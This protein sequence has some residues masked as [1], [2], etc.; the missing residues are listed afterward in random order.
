MQDTPDAKNPSYVAMEVSDQ[1][2]AADKQVSAAGRRRTRLSGW[3]LSQFQVTLAI[4][5]IVIG[6]LVC[7]G[8]GFLSGVWFQT[9]GQIMPQDD[10]ITLADNQL[11]R[12]QK[13]SPGDREMTFYSALPSRDGTPEP[14]LPPRTATA[15]GPQ[16]ERQPPPT[17]APDASS[18]SASQSPPPRVPEAVQPEVAELDQAEKMGSTPLP[19]S[20]S[21]GRVPS[22][23]QVAAPAPPKATGEALA[24]VVPGEQFYIVQVGS[25]RKVDQ[26]YHLQD[27]LVKKGYEARIGLSMVEGKG[28]WYRVRVGRYADRGSADETAQRLQ[29]RENIDSLVMRVSP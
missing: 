5:G 16:P 28:A 18:A 15:P 1:A 2:M 10:A 23:P 27:Q 22:E 11:D 26:A 25:F 6:F 9:P 19:A 7:F 4:C 13:T 29:K 14:E 17:V 12:E 20:A 24:A 8:L 3:V 21:P